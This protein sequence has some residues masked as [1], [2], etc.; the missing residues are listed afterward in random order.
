[1]NGDTPTIASVNISLLAS[2]SYMTQEEVAYITPTDADKHLAEKVLV[3]L[4]QK[5]E[6]V[7][8][9]RNTASDYDFK[10]ASAVITG[11]C[12]FGRKS[13]PTVGPLIASVFFIMNQIQREEFAAA[14][15]LDNP[16]ETTLLNSNIGDKVTFTGKVI[17]IREY[18][19]NFGFRPTTSTMV[20]V[21]VGGTKVR[22][23]STVVSSDLNEG[24]EVTIKATIKSIDNNPKF[25]ITYNVN[26]PK[27]L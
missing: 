17:T 4:Q 26:R 23:F 22:F 15:K 9:N 18:E 20:I 8:G 19:N 24:D 5:A 2:R 16:T 14:P 12:S 11:F 13:D 7:K 25:G 6:E 27:F 3:R 10:V 21:K 1:M